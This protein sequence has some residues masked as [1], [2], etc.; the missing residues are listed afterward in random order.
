MP[1]I[2]PEGPNGKSIPANSPA[3]PGLPT[4]ACVVCEKPVKLR[5]FYCLRCKAIVG[6]R[7]DKLLFRAALHDSHDKAIDRF[8]CAVSG[9]V[10]DETGPYGPYYITANHVYPGRK[11]IVITGRLFNDMQNALTLDEFVTVV[12]ALDDTLRG[13]APFDK[14][15]IRFVAWDRMPAAARLSA[16]LPLASW[17]RTP[18]PVPACVICGHEPYPGSQYCATCRHFIYCRDEFFARVLALKASWDPVLQAFIC[19]YTGVPLD[20]ADPK[21][22]WYLAFDHLVPGQKGNIAAC[23]FWVNEMKYYLTEAQFRAVIHSLA[24]HFRHGT[25]FDRSLVNAG[26][27]AMAARRVGGNLPTPRRF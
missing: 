22:P 15:I 4:S 2:V 25:E 6:N 18:K 19:R 8:R 27:Y 11:E 23:A 7:V 16:R 1:K 14:N 26:M 20:V 13:I 5:C 3:M 17:E 21:S 12:P 10:L 9:A 24:E